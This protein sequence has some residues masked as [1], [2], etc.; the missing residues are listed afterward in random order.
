MAQDWDIKPRGSTCGACQTAFADRS[1]CYS[2][3]VFGESGYARQDLCEACWTQRQREGKPSYSVWQGVFRAPPPPAEEP[4]KKEN[5]ENLLRKLMEVPDPA[6]ANVIYILA[7]MLERKKVLVE[8]DV[9]THDGVMTRAYEHK[10]TGET[11]LIVDPRLKLTELES[12][13]GE[14]V[15]LL[16]GRTT[17]AA[18]VAEA[19]APANA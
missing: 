1:V 19:P 15:A 4:L 6:R 16:G 10:R 8:R 18:P 13:Q 17:E 3:L 9:Q 2:S 5:A 14:V 11:F 12:V 7:V